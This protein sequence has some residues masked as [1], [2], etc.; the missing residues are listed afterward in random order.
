MTK[1][2][3]EALFRQ[4]GVDVGQ[5]SNLR[6]GKRPEPALVQRQREALAQVAK[7]LEAQIQRDQTLVASLQEQVQ[8]LN[9][10]GGR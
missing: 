6:P 3:L 8:R 10:G 4:A 5:W 9:H 7:L 1:E 2:E